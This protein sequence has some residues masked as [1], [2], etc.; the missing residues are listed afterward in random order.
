MTSFSLIFKPLFVTLLLSNTAAA[1]SL[2]MTCIGDPNAKTQAIFLHG[3]ITET[4]GKGPQPDYSIQLT[5]VAKKGN[6][7]IAM[8][9]SKDPCRG[10]PKKKCWSGNDGKE[11][12]AIWNDVVTASAAC[13]DIKKPFGLIGHSN[14]G[15]MTGRIIMRCLKPQPKWAIAGGAAGDISHTVGVDTK[16]CAALT[17]FI[18]KKDLTNQK[19]KKF[20]EQLKE[21]KRNATL[22]EYDGVHDFEVNSLVGLI[23]TLE[24]AE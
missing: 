2:D 4:K 17:V 18:G 1:I 11:I 22:I 12:A 19:A 21:K 10:D 15:Y 7:R 20:V 5:Q 16:D 3:F 8:P 6:L 9:V 14:G 23:G 13:I 24:K